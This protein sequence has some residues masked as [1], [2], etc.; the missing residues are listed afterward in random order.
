MRR[1]RGIAF[2]YL[3]PALDAVPAL[4]EWRL[5]VMPL[6]SPLVATFGSV[7]PGE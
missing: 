7:P 1:G 2:G 6:P 4:R 5:L 3:V